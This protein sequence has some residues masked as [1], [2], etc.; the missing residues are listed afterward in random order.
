VLRTVDDVRGALAPA[1]AA[2]E[3][4][5]L[6]PT[7]GALHPG[8][9]ALVRRARAECD[10]VLV[11]LFVNPTQFDEEADLADYPRAERRDAELARQAGADALF[12]P[13]ASEMYPRGFATVVEVQGLGER[14]E[15]AVRGPG[16][17][18][19][20]ATVVLKLLN[21]VAPDVAY[22]GQKDAQQAVLVRTM[23]RDLDVPV[24]VVVCPTVRDRDGLAR[25]S[26]NARLS[27]AERGRA[28]AL[29]RGLAA[30]A[31]L[32]AEGE[33]S[34]ARLTGAV[35]ALLGEHGIE[36]QYIELVDADTLVPLPEL[37]RKALLLVAARLGRTRL[38]DN[39]ELVPARV[40]AREPARET[41][42]ETA[43]TKRGEEAIACNG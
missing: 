8:H 5:G 20:V 11:S 29:H 23:V 15:G 34:A 16:H 33:R 2:G 14:L 39:V 42:R 4:I 38:I 24:R 22:F 3:R 21:I 43:R 40:P 36:A 18:R 6:V 10:R 30:A 31:A 32:A 12:A 35:A 19:G 9:L 28:P 26:R 41:A 37:D 1:R 7:M 13:D 25:S 27:A 17:F